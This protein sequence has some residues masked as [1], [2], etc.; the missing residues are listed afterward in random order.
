MKKSLTIILSLIILTTSVLSNVA[1]VKAVGF[2]GVVASENDSSIEMQKGSDTPEDVIEQPEGNMLKDLPISNPEEEGI[3][4]DNN[5]DVEEE[6]E[7]IDEETTTEEED[8]TVEETAEEPKQ[9]NISPAAIQAVEESLSDLESGADYE[10]GE[11]LVFFHEE[12]EVNE[13]VELLEEAETAD[14][15]AF[16]EADMIAEDIVLVSL[17]EDVSIAEAIAEFNENPEVAFS[18]PNFIYETMEEGMEEILPQ[19]TTISD[20][21]RSQQWGLTTG[22]I[23]D[24]WSL[25]RTNRRVSIAILDTGI[26]GT[27]QDL[28]PNIYPNSFFDVT[29]ENAT[30]ADPYG[31]GTHV[32][33]IAAAA[34]NN[35]VG[36]AGVSYDAYIVPIKVFFARADGTGYITNTK[37]LVSAFDRLFNVGSDG[38][39]LAQ[40]YNVK[41]INMSLGGY[42]KDSGLETRINNAFAAGVL[43]VAAAGNDKTSNP[44]YPASFTNCISV[45]ALKQG[46]SRSVLSDV[47]DTAYSNFG[48][49]VNLAAPGTRIYST[50]RTGNTAYGNM[51]GTSMA[52]PYVAGAAALAFA[53]NP[54]ATAAQVRDVLQNTAIDLGTPGRDDYYGFGQV[55]PYAAVWQ[56]ATKEITNTTPQ[57]VG[58]PITFSVRTSLPVSMQWRWSV[59]A[60]DGTISS[61]GVLTPVRSGNITVRATYVND[62]NY[63]ITKSVVVE[64]FALTTANTTVSNIANQNY[65]GSAVNP[66]GMVVTF[67]NA[68]GVSTTLRAGTDYTISYRNNILPT[69]GGAQAIITGI[70]RYS[71]S[72]VRNF[73]IIGAAITYQ[74]NVQSLGW[75]PTVQ[76]GAMAGT[77]GRSLRMEALQLNLINNTGISGGI[78]IASHVQNIGWQPNR[79]ASSTGTNSLVNAAPFTGTTG[80]GLRLEA[81]RVNLTGEL[82]RSYDVHYRLHVQNIGWTGWTKNGN[83]AGSAGYGLRV[84]GIQIFLTPKTSPS[85]GSN[86]LGVVSSSN[87]PVFTDIGLARQGGTVLY[88][89]KAH[90]QNVGDINYARNNGSTTMGTSG[91]GLRIESL[92]MSLVNQPVPG[93]ITYQAHVQNIGWQPRVSNGQLAGTS[94]RGL[95]LEAFNM[96]LTGEM[97]NQYDIYYRVHAQNIGW[98]GWAK[99]GQNAGT[100]GMSLR[101]EAIQVIIVPKNTVAPGAN[102]DFFRSR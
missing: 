54:S 85:P 46:P 23:Y 99:N 74:A 66:T 76:N 57:G 36:V 102:T 15:E 81:L 43:V 2:A 24:T 97:A 58:N 4:S 26:L 51:T 65:T 8:K 75:M 17:N 68:S 64:N 35:G 27:H 101:L 44:M 5:E 52:A 72:I 48:S 86:F 37:M 92:S 89:A 14:E 1:V 12:K 83:S 11:I 62:T 82:A 7:N 87:N 25:S 47:F 98:M 20:P 90:V 69:N 96:N 30:I 78:T 9:S 40:T 80:Q 18:Q 22:R 63:F 16:I 41:V 94:G 71:G 42:A 61:A 73:S 45:S 31:H 6:T 32:A 84:E 88:Q 100:A 67:R 93:G 95:R 50:L 49:N 29:G 39:T 79:V 70:G 55:N 34:T 38:K 53:A 59:A 3:T 10:E 56:I 60:A 21:G 19:N 91:R 28:A 13:V 33:G 77:S